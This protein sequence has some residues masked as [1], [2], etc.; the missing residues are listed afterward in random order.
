MEHVM[1]CANWYIRDMT[2][3]EEEPDSVFGEEQFA[4]STVTE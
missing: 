3:K 4:I 1:K 2:H